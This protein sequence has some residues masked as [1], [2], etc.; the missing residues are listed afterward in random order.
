MAGGGKT[1]STLRI[2]YAI[3]TGSFLYSFLVLGLHGWERGWSEVFWV[4]LALQ[5]LLYPHLLYWRARRSARPE[6]AERDNLI[7]DSALLGTWS[8][9][10]GFPTWISFALIG[11]T[12]LNAAVNR[13]APGI[14]ISLACSAAGALAWIA[15]GGLQRLPATSD[16]VTLLCFAGALAYSCFVGYVVHRQ[17]R[18]LS[19]TRRAL[20]QSEE[21]YR[22]IAEN[23]ADLIAMVDHEA[24]WLYTSPS[25]GQ[26]LGAADLGPGV[27]AF[28]RAHPEDAETAR[29]AVARAAATGKGRELGL[30]MV[31]CDGRMRQFH[32]R[33]HA[34]EKAATFRRVLL[35]SRDVT[36]LRASEER[37]L[38]AAHALEGMTEGIMITAA[39]GTVVTVNQAF[40][41]IT[42]YTRDDVLGQPEQAIR[43]ALRPPEFYD[44]VYAAVLREGYWSGTTWNRR[45]NGS[46][47]REWRSVRAVRDPAGKVTHY[48]SVFYELGLS[49][50][51]EGAAGPR[52]GA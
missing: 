12:L 32:V 46:V 34:L 9:Y 49:K 23:A 16:R 36:D 4:L 19:S 2:N 7:L 21:R 25:Y 30:R 13:G 41:E 35:V 5:F 10:L 50:T 15:I 29:I 1:H 44:D 39:D 8:A 24:K 45:R 6:S 52:L 43:N 40:C 28:A 42:G 26:F 18:H 38:L 14:A 48:V 31:D 47:Y 33:V 37:L 3:R 51:V 17:N 27:D 11:S 20:R 22:L